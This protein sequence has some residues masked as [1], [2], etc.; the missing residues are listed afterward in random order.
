MFESHRFWTLPCRNDWN[1]GK[2][3][4]PSG[5]ILFRFVV[6]SVLVETWNGHFVGGQWQQAL[7]LFCCPSMVTN[8]DVI[9]YS[10]LISACEKGSQWPT[11]LELF[12]TMKFASLAPNKYSFSAAII[13]C[14]K[15][16]VLEKQN[17]TLVKQPV[18]VGKCPC[19]CLLWAL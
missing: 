18:V 2:N 1:A 16:E 8:R 13:S 15:G 19:F 10:A 3:T 6:Q 17:T 7:H 9:S 5:L 11:A 12:H 4:N 14:Q